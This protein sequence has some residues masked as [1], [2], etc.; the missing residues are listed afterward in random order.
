MKILNKK[1]GQ[2]AVLIAV[3]LIGIVSLLALV[4]DTGRI[5][6]EHTKLQ[7]GVDAAVLAAVQDMPIGK[8]GSSE[9]SVSEVVMKALA[10]NLN[11]GE[12]TYTKDQNLNK[13]MLFRDAPTGEVAITKKKFNIETP[14]TVEGLPEFEVDIQFLTPANSLDGRKSII[15]VTAN[16]TIKTRMAAIL[17]YT[18]WTISAQQIAIIGPIKAVPE[19]LPLG[20][21][22]DTDPAT[23]LPEEIPLHQVVRLSNTLHDSNSLNQMTYV[24]IFGYNNAFR[25]YS[26]ADEGSA[27]QTTIDGSGDN[28]F[29]YTSSVKNA[30]E[31]PIRNKNESDAVYFGICK[32]FNRRISNS[33]FNSAIGCINTDTAID[34]DIN[35]NFSFGNTT[36]RYGY[37]EDP[38]MFLVPIIQYTTNYTVNSLKI[39]GRQREFKIIGFALFFYQYG[40]Y[41]AKPATTEYYEVSTFEGTEEIPPAMFEMVGFFTD[42]IF[43]GPIDL[44]TRD[45]GI[46]GIEYVSPNNE[47]LFSITY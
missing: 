39:N 17:G 19:V 21:L 45:Y 47:D 12:Q 38:R 37:E 32:G 23:G 8:A 44:T 33:A 41:T 4:L 29:I 14:G 25:G 43:E 22:V 7:R 46:S 1:Q 6:V 34:E 18:K 13:F 40:H 24:P 10:Y 16:K 36:A 3:C 15:S 20:V 30:Q 27:E 9:G 35:Y 26:V 42:A 28:H 2:A 11:N 5:F 31:V